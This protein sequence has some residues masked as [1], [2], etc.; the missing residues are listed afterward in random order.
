[1]ECV[2]VCV[3]VHAWVHMHDG[4]VLP[5]PVSVV[6]VLANGHQ[7]KWVMYSIDNGPPDH[8]VGI[9]ALHFMSAW[10]FYCEPISP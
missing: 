5:P 2:C 1:M 9:H 8:T 4:R 7:T 10:K 6:Q 3:Y